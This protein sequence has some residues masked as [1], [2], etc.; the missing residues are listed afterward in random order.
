MKYRDHIMRYIILCSYP[1]HKTK[2]ILVMVLDGKFSNKIRKKEVHWVRFHKT[3]L[4]LIK[5]RYISE[6]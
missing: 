6:R 2:C 3:E 4:Q 5:A 1:I